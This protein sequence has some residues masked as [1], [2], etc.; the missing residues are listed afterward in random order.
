M[1]YPAAQPLI[2]KSKGDGIM[3]CLILCAKG[4]AWKASIRSSLPSD[5]PSAHILEFDC[6]D[7]GNLSVYGQV[8]QHDGDVWLFA[9]GSKRYDDASTVRNKAFV[10]FGTFDSKTKI[11][12]VINNTQLATYLN[13]AGARRLFLFACYQGALLQDYILKIPSL[14]HCEGFLGPMNRSGA[15]QYMK[16]YFQTPEK[17]K[18]LDVAADAGAVREACAG[19]IASYAAA[20]ASMARM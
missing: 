16:T 12:N 3:P 10:I 9:H 7:H 15:G 20:V 13:H 11:G 2:Y 6:D 14:N 1:F 18:H 8:P 17:A 4:D 19:S 5:F